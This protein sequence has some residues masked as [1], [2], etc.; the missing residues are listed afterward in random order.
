MY[1]TDTF[2]EDFSLFKI[3]LVKCNRV[4]SGKTLSLSC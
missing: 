2:S 4:L 1:A 3:V